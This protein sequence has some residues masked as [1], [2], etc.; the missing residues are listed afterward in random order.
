MVIM[1]YWG[2]IYDN[3]ES[4]QEAAMLMTENDDF[5]ECKTNLDT[6]KSLLG[7]MTTPGYDCEIPFSKLCVVIGIVS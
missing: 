4:L 2:I 1:L 6:V 5:L 7:I 3:N